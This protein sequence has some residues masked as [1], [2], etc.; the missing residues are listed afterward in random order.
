MHPSVVQ[1][2]DRNIDKTYHI[3]NHKLLGHEVHSYRCYFIL[4]K[5]IIT[6]KKIFYKLLNLCK[7]V[8]TRL[9]S[10]RR[11]SICYCIRGRI[12]LK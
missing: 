3:H 1:P 11:D 2:Y 9:L 7:H 8:V 4:I 12:I 6:G 10:Q 5:Q